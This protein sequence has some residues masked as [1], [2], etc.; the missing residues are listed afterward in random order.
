[1]YEIWRFRRVSRWE[2]LLAI[3]ATPPLIGRNGIFQS[4]EP[5]KTKDISF[6]MIFA[7]KDG[8]FYIVQGACTN[9]GTEFKARFGANRRPASSIPTQWLELKGLNV[10]DLALR[11][12]RVLLRGIRQECRA[13]IDLCDKKK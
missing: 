13:A 1:M 2:W 5:A 12:R 6:H 9:L 8:D 3:S 4:A 11:A 7:K 10:D